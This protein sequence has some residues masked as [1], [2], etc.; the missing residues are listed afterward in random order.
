MGAWTNLAAI[1]I[2]AS[3][4]DAHSWATKK[5]VGS[6]AGRL[7]QLIIDVLTNQLGLSMGKK[8]LRD[9]RLSFLNDVLRR[10]QMWGGKGPITTT[11]QL[12]FGAASAVIDWLESDSA[13][14]DM[15]AWLGEQELPYTEEMF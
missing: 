15:A 1:A 2:N 10:V 3:S 6:V 12:S 11:K 9:L 8:S 14:E 13:A 7:G 5:Q 4:G